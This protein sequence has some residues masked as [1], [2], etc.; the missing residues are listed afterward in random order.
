VETLIPQ[1]LSLSQQISVALTVVLYHIATPPWPMHLPQ[2]MLLNL[3]LHLTIEANRTKI[4]AMTINLMR[5]T[6]I[7]Q[8]FL[9]THDIRFW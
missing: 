7:Q 4:F 1:I 2:S 3:L 6:L 8:M 9:R 5:F